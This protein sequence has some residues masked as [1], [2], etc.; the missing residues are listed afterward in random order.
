MSST[1][2]YMDQYLSSRPEKTRKKIRSMIDRREVY[3]YEKKIGKTIFEMSSDEIIDMVKGFSRRGANKGK[4]SL[5]TYDIIF[6]LFRGLFDWY[7]EEVNVIINPF[8]SRSFREKVSEVFAERREHIID[9]NIIEKAISNLYANEIPEYAEYCEAIIRMAFEG[10]A[11]THD[12]VSMK[13][14]DV[15]HARRSV[16]IRGTEHLLSARLYSL[17]VKIHN[18]EELPAH[19]GYFVLIQYEDSY[20]KFP[21]RE[22][23]VDIKRES[24]YWQQYISRV[25]NNKIVP[26]FECEVTFRDIYLCGLYEYIVKKYG[27]EKTDEMILSDYDGEANAVLTNEA[28]EYGI[29]AKNI[30][31]SYIR[32]TLKRNF[33]PYVK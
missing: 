22:S 10:F 24:M 15:N 1:K 21:T 11:T 2:D 13:E 5:K 14:K 3:D 29:N 30:S 7:I 32:Q 19:R 25:F 31:Q 16:T 27:K 17:L 26:C 20:F 6:S 33:F 18:A 9:K 23:F 4:L 28:I 12:I 8:N